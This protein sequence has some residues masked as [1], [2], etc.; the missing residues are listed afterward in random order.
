MILKSG[1]NIN[2]PLRVKLR[3]G[4]GFCLIA[5]L[6]WHLSYMFSFSSIW[7]FTES[8]ILPE[9]SVKSQESQK[10]SQDSK[11][12]VGSEPP[13][14]FSRR[15]WAESSG[16]EGDSSLTESR[17]QDND[18]RGRESNLARSLAEDRAEDEAF[19]RAFAQPWPEPTERVRM[20]LSDSEPPIIIESDEMREDQGSKRLFFLGSVVLIKGEEQVTG[21]RALWD[22]ATGS[23]EVS[24]HVTIKT[25]DFS[26]TAARAAVNLD[27]KLAK[28]YDGKAFFPEN[29][30]YVDGQVIERQGPE[31]VYVS[32][33]AFT[34]CDG[35]DPS[36]SIK[37]TNLMINRGGVATATNTRFYN[38]YFP[39][40]YFP[41]FAAPINRDRQTGFLVPT[42]GNSTRDGFYASLPFFLE[43]AEDYDLTVLPVYRADRGLSMTLEARYNFS[44]GQGIWLVTYLSDKHDNWYNFLSPG[45]TR[46]NSKDLYW[47]R[48]LNTWRYHDWDMSLDIDYVS[49]PFYL[50]AF[51]NDPDGFYY[52]QRA[53]SNFFGRGVNEELDPTRLSIFSAQKQT[54]DTFFRGSLSYTQ[55]LWREHNIDTLQNLP[56]L[57]YNL[58]SRPLG[59]NFLSLPN[60]LVGPRLS[61]D[62]QY[63]FFTRESNAYSYITETGHRFRAVPSLFWNHNFGDIFTLKTDLGLNYSAYAPSG[64]R[65]SQFGQE[66]HPGFKSNL[67]GSFEIE[68]STA[69]SRVYNAGLG[70][71]TATLHKIEPVVAFEFVQAPDQD[72]LPY[73]DMYDRRLNR[74]TF[75]Y[76]LRNSLVSKTPVKDAN[77]QVIRND[78]RQLLRFGIF[79]S[80]EFASNIEKATKDWAR[81]YTTG[82]FDRGVGP[83]EFEV[84]T[85]FTP[86]MSA[87]LISSLDGRTGEFTRHEISMNLRDQRGDSLNVLYDYDSPNIRQGPGQPNTISQIRG[88]ANL[89]LGGGWSA[90]FSQRF[91]FIRDEPLE[92]FMTLRYNSQCYAV[93]VLYSDSEDDRRIGIVF[94]FLGLGSFGTPTTSLTS[95]GR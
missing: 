8:N 29:H 77:G 81:Y 1:H 73:F 57:Q 38:K 3:A 19:E 14:D 36:W 84:E 10:I 91:D 33:A 11:I 85:S 94:D 50:W 28:I 89:N 90:H 61:V 58:V 78:Y 41:W 6:I 62:L 48:A 18:F 72:T 16:D 35:P 55:N 95:G 60:D 30:F 26:A 71:A 25:P 2:R 53:F 82:Y 31:T 9:N 12:E 5:V 92:T 47:V 20:I 49:D 45:N 79:S 34:S 22:D 17:D 39:M 54:V 32:Q 21:D 15:E 24:G 67:S 93:S 44:Q 52:S 74:R 42:V 46:R 40:I 64:L 86:G 80:Y 27:L 65:P 88:D 75:R 51:R 70:Q 7:A 69:L 59:L 37:A 66:A 87:R 43:L 63:D 23:A 68:L 13:M 56:K 83:V 76:G 4:A